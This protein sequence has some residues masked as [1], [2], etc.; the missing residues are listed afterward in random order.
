MRRFRSLLID[1]ARIR[2]PGLGILS[3]AVHR[4]LSEHASI[5]P[6]RHAWCQALLYLGGHGRQR[7][8]GRD[9]PVAPGTLVVVPPGVDHAFGRT[10]GRPPLCLMINFRVMAGSRG[11]PVVCSLTRAELALVREHLA[12][13]P[14]AGG[15]EILAQRWEASL[16]ILQLFKLL[17]RAAGWVEH[18]P[19]G[20]S[21]G[22]DAAVR[23]M[24]ARMDYTEPLIAVARRSGYHRDHLNRLVKRATGLTLGQYRAQR[25]LEQAR[26]LLATGLRVSTVAATVGLPDSS[27]FA[28]WFRRQTGQS[29]SRYS[30]E[31]S[32]CPP[33]LG[34]AWSLAG[35]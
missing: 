27:Y 16:T 22:G 12:R 5:E 14:G 11:P 30:Q 28:R 25:R 7:I 18:Q 21:T 10:A 26:K 20:V 3:L 9:F 29:P 34:A 2:L 8:A 33:R 17:L 31:R 19:A 1:R 6:H 24:L 4:H 15:I 35:S 23:E 13:L 32:G